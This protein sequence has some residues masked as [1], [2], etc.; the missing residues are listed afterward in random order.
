MKP[1]W[2]EFWFAFFPPATRIQFPFQ[3][4]S[5]S[6]VPHP[7]NLFPSLDPNAPTITDA[8]DDELGTTAQDIVEAKF[9]YSAATNQ[10]IYT[11]TVADLSVK[12]PN[13]RWTLTSAFGQTQAHDERMSD[14]MFGL[15]VY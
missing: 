10:I 6:A 11:L 5:F 13:M 2:A 12:T 15:S 7:A 1:F 3:Q 14:I 8:R 4:L 9:R